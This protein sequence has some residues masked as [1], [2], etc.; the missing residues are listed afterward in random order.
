MI[1]GRATAPRT[2]CTRPRS[3]I[4]QTSAPGGGREMAARLGVEPVELASDHAVFTLRPPELASLLV[5]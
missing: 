5:G 1:S 4:P 2:M 3:D